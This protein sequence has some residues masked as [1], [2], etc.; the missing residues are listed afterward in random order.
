MYLPVVALNPGRMKTRR[1]LCA[2]NHRA[3]EED[4]PHTTAPQ[5]FLHEDSAA[6]IPAANRCEGDV[7]ESHGN[8]TGSGDVEGVPDLHR[9]ALLNDFRACEHLIKSQAD[10]HAKDVAG[11]TGTFLPGSAGD[12]TD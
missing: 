5:P 11:R 12:K 9:A 7:D 8:A 4:K 3:A 2:D 6:N 10:V 1:L